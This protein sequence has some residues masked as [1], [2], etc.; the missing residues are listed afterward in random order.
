MKGSIEKRGKNSWRLRIDLGY[1]PDGT[2]NR[3][4]KTITVEDPALLRTKKKLRDYLED[5]LA[6]FK[7]EVLSSTY[8]KPEKTTFKEFVDK[9]WRPKFASDPDNLAPSTLVVYDQHLATHIIPSFGHMRLDDIQTMHVVDFLAYLKTPEARKDGKPGTLG[10]GTQRDILKVLRNV[11]NIAVE[12]KFIAQ[13]P[14]DGVRWPKKPETKIEVY[15]EPEI[16]EIIDALYQQP[17][18]WWLLIL[19]TFLGGFRRG[20]IVAV[21]I[22]DC[23]FGDNS[24]LIDENIPMKIDRE[25]LIKAPKTRSSVRKVKMPAWYME[26]LKEYATKEWKRQRW[27]A[28]SKWKAPEGRQFLFHKGD[29]LPYHPNY[30]TRWWREFLKKNGFRHIKL[31]ALR[32]TSATFLL[33][34]GLTARAVAERLGHANEKTLLSTYSHVTK[35]MEER[36][37]Q[38]FDRFQRRPKSNI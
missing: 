14:C 32:H 17:T 26:E 38:E 21:E 28:G 11:L 12:W 29:G 16:M 31:H 4:S 18:V 2:R 19:G 33:E 27:A 30:V 9:H 1:N 34:Q 37:A 7:R 35:S 6:I 22:S 10:N 3:P 8:I 15:D 20:E 25:Y 5:Q 23:D 24:I 13:N 36:A